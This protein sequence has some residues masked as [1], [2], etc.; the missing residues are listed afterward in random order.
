MKFSLCIIALGAA[1][2]AAGFFTRETSPAAKSGPTKA[3]TAWLE[4]TLR[5]G[6]SAHA[7]ESLRKLAAEDPR[8]FFKELEHFPRL[9]GID[10]LVT[11]AAGKLAAGNPAD[12]AE[13]LNRISNLQFK[14]AAWMGFGWTS[15][16]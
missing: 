1:G 6:D 12:A 11:L 5:S 10:E 7:L 16:G 3:A 9:D 4:S 14:S 13:L 2:F 8:A 15:Y